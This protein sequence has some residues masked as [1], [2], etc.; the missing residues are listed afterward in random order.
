VAKKFR[1]ELEVVLR[2]RV[3]AEQERQKEVARLETQ[4]QQL[5]DQAIKMQRSMVLSRDLMRGQLS[6]GSS[7]RIDDIRAQASGSLHTMIE[8]QR[9]ALQAAGLHQKL[10]IA[11]Q[12]L[13]A[14]T[15]QRKAVQTLKDKQLARWKMDAE[16][17]E[18]AELDD[19]VLMRAGSVGDVE[20][21]GS[22]A[23]AR[24]R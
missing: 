11:R 18:T 5:M 19:L 6:A 7:V 16:R 9:V 3:R 23:I 2:M 21:T 17:R 15:V 20:N 24:A 8:L 1:F 10:A 4:R 12:Q 14:A 22:R 13:L